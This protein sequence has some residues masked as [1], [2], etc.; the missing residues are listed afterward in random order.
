M[1]KILSLYLIALSLY[2][3]GDKSTAQVDEVL[4]TNDLKQIQEKR[5]DVHQEYEKLA[6]QMA[7]LDA[8]IVKLDDTKRYPLVRTLTVKD[9]AFTHFIEVQGNI[10]T[11]ENIFIYPEYSGV[12][13][14]L[15]VKSGQNVSKGQ[16]LARIDDSGMSA[17]VAQAQ[18]KL[19]LDKT[20]FDRQKNLWDQKIG[21]EIQYLQT[22]T[23]Y[24]S[25][26][27]MVKQMQAQLA[28][29]VIRAPFSGTIDE[30][31]I[32]RGQVVSPG[33]ALFRIVNLGNMYVSA[34]VPENY[35]GVLKLGATVEVYLNAI[36][37]TYKG[38]VRQVGTFINPNNRTF[39]IE[40]ALPNPD[41]L[42]RPNQVAVLKIEDYTK[43]DALLIPENII[44]EN[45]NKEKVVYVITN[46][47]E[48]KVAQRIIQI[49]YTSGAMV[50]VKS[51]LQLGEIIVTDGAK[52]LS[53]GANVEIIK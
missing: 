52:S 8:A 9:S 40:I 19:A 45:A 5:N 21:S 26:Q 4:A 29:T 23:A 16:V 10:D 14:Q 20:T 31:I 43:K 15:N 25:Q 38:K 47:K 13:N 33:D 2:S 27:K 7:L 41:N 39:S 44:I 46:Q 51:G 3:C 48:P 30:V 49:G 34:N 36:G 50:E 11:N 22:Q 37:K 53:D 12:L 42:L 6:A 28:K 32:E 35:L 24:Q 1:K 17:Q 18:A